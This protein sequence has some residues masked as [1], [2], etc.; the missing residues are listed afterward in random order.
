[1]DRE[2]LLLKNYSIL[3]KNPL[4]NADALRATIAHLCEVSPKIAI[5]CWHDLIQDNLG[6]ILSA[7]NGG[8]FEYDSLGCKLIDEFDS[9]IIGEPFFRD[10]A[11]EFASDR[12]LLEMVFSLCPIP[13]FTRVYYLISYLIRHRYLNHAD[14]VLSAIYKNKTFSAYSDLWRDTV[15][16][17]HCY[18][19]D[20]YSGSA[21]I[22]DDY[23]KQPAEVQEF[24][25]SWA[26]RIPDEEEQAGAISHILRIY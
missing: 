22:N 4:K 6:Q 17:F 24:C 13:R 1:M 3:S 2:D 11:V 26:E 16:L 15:E 5:R 8:E 18:E 9:N 7:I 14:A 23:Y 25:M 12:Q 21:Y 10:A 20:Y 19:P